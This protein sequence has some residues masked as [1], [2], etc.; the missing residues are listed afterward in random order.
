M[1]SLG[2]ELPKE[3]N[4]VRDIQEHYKDLRRS[5]G[6]IVEPAIALMEA[7]IKEGI[8]AQGSGDVVRM[9]RAYENLKG[10]EL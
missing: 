5:P 6:V 9:L 4:R 8:E 10:F 1:A 2:I 7:A 3:I